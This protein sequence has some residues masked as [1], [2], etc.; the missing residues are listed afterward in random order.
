[1][2]YASPVQLR[3]PAKR[4]NLLALM[5]GPLDVLDI[6]LKRISLDLSEADFEWLERL[7]S[8]RNSLALAEKRRITPWSRKSLCESFVAVQANAQREMLREMIAALGDLPAADDSEALS[9]YVAK[10]L[11]WSKKHNK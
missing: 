11:A 4:L 8:F 9:A 1:M 2:T 5:A 10:V 7:A 3:K 6:D